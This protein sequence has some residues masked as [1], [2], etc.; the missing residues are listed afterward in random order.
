MNDS[1]Y[2][3]EIMHLAKS[4][5]GAGR[6]NGGRTA[7]GSNP[8]CGDECSLSARLQDGRIAAIAHETRGCL[9]CSAAAAK[10]ILLARQTPHVDALRRL[11]KAFADNLQNGKP[12]PPELAI[13]TPLVGRKSRHLCVLL[14]FAAFL[15]LSGELTK[16]GES[17]IIRL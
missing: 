7:H 3:E 12:P 16:E 13:F 15:N 4:T 14:P 9:L 8:L 10:L 2:H 17:D 1:L 5:E 6:I 11:A